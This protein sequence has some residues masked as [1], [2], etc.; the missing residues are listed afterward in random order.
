MA[1]RK[2]KPFGYGLYE[3]VAKAQGGKAPYRGERA[4]KLD[5][6]GSFTELF[7]MKPGPAHEIFTE[8]YPVTKSIKKKKK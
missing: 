7:K 3:S 6:I 8:S 5:P 2:R 1:T 4:Y